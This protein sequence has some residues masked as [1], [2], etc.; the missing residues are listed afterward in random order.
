[1][2]GSYAEIEHRVIVGFELKNTHLKLPG[3]PRIVHPTT[4]LGRSKPPQSQQT[5]EEIRL[6]SSSAREEVLERRCVLLKIA[7]MTYSLAR[8]LPAPLRQRGVEG[9]RMWRLRE[10]VVEVEC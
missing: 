3:R 7:R 4:T 2:E 1:M 5:T 9:W 6:V 8:P 10:F